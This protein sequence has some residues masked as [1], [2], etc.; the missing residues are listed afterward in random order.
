MRLPGFCTFAAL[1]QVN[2]LP[3]FHPDWPAPAP[4]FASSWFGGSL[5]EAEWQ[6]PNQMTQLRKYK[7]VLTSW[8]LPFGN[9][10]NATA[11]ASSQAV[12]LKESLG[13]RNRRLHVPIRHS[14]PGFYPE[15][16][17]VMNDTDLYGDFFPQDLQRELS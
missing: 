6:D 9:F 2:A 10:V 14:R 3:P 8:I 1:L 12:I 4:A 16:Q 13:Q 7:A 11:I 5:T 15:N 17:V